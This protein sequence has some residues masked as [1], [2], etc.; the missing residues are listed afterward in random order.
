MRLTWASFMDPVGWQGS[1]VVVSHVFL[2]KDLSGSL[3][4]MLADIQSCSTLLQ[5]FL[6]GPSF[7]RTTMEARIAT[8]N[9]EVLR[10]LPYPALGSL[11]L[12]SLFTDALGLRPRYLLSTLWGDLRGPP[13]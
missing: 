7:S 10:W 11:S 12:I 4:S 2:W 13:R 6:S 8:P 1:L 5:F 3:P 9:L